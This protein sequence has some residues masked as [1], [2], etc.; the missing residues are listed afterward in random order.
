MQWPS[1]SGKGD[2][3]S[4]LF[5]ALCLWGP[6]VGA[7][8]GGRDRSALCVSR[9]TGVLS[10]GTARVWA[11]AGRSGGTRSRRMKNC[12]CCNTTGSVSPRPGLARAR[13]GLAELN[14]ALLNL[15]QLCKRSPLLAW[16]ISRRAV[17]ARLVRPSALGYGGIHQLEPTLLLLKSFKH[18][19]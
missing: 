19:A 4:R 5:P 2:W 3:G 8:W 1:W 13:E 10:C 14:L 6:G 12:R 15:V 16:P 9:Q 7:R 18:F 17:P 11:V